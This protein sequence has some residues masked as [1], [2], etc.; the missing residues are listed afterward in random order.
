MILA[1]LSEGNLAKEVGLLL[2]LSRRVL[3]LNLPLLPLLHFPK[4]IHRR[5][6]G[7]L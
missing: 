2:V 6:C 7:L 4:I 5:C 3:W 1:S